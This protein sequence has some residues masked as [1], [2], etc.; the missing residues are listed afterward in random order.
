MFVPFSVDGDP[1]NDL[2]AWA[3]YVSTV[4]LEDRVHLP[5]TL[6]HTLNPV[7]PDFSRSGPGQTLRDWARREKTSY[8]LVQEITLA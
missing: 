2:E 3:R 6:R 5:D 1:I 4:A 7:G 8:L